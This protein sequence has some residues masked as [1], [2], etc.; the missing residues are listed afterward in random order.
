MNKKAFTLVELIV[1]IAII[2]I[3]WTISFI[4]LQWYSKTSRDSTR[5]SD[6]STMKSSLELFNLDSWKYPNP[7][8]W[9]DVTYSWTFLVWN[10]W[11]FGNQTTKNISRL[12]RIPLDPLTW[13]PYTYSVNYNKSLYQIA[14]IQEWDE[15]S[16][17][18]SISET[19]AWNI[20]AKA[21]I[22]WNYKWA[23]I[24]TLAWSN[25]KVLI[26]PSIISSF[27]S[28]VNDLSDIYSSWGLVF[29]WYKN[30]PNSFASTKFNVN[31]WFEFMPTNIE[32]YSDSES[33]NP[34]YSSSDSSAR[35][36]LI[37]NVALLYS[38]SI[39]ENSSEVQGA[40][41]EN[42][43]EFLISTVVVNHLWGDIWNLSTSSDLVNCTFDFTNLDH[44]VLP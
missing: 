22:R 16:L 11:I 36:A 24:K 19:N 8:D 9:F 15:Y 30:L 21:I 1:V 17:N 34:L 38:G 13:I 42:S 31:W 14:W 37:D 7:T 29:S 27:D 4:S 3:L 44:C 40:I 10:Q 39:V 20:E 18:S 5:I 33:C 41:V 12:D 2:A 35:D 6:L 23:I 43:D 26:A 28:S 25:C 32:A